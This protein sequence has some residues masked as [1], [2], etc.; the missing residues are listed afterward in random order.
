VK[1][2][3][4]ARNPRIEEQYREKPRQ[5]RQTS[6]APCRG[7]IFF[8]SITRGYAA[9]L[10]RFTP[11][12]CS[13]CASGAKKSKSKWHWGRQRGQQLHC[14]QRNIVTGQAPWNVV[15]KQSDIALS[16]PVAAKQIVLN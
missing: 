8:L 3:E 2:C 14:R 4:A 10:R 12:Y 6:A 11:V 16:F 13:V 15:Q 5:G 1:R 7:L 9:A